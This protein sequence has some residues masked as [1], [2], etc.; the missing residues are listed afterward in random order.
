MDPGILVG[1]VIAVGLILPMIYWNSINDWPM[2]H[3]YQQFTGDFSGGGPLNFFITQIAII[4]I[5][6]APIF[7]IG[8]YFYLRSNEGNGLRA[9]GLTYIILYIFMT[10]LNLKT[11]Y[12]M[13]VY[14]MLYAG[15]ALL[16]EK[17]SNS[18][19]GVFRWFGSRPFIAS[20]VV[21]AL[22]LAPVVM[23]ILSPPT[24][25][26]KYGSSDYQMVNA[27]RYGWSKMVSNLS[28]AYDV[29]PVYVKD[30]ACIFTSN[31][32]E[33]S[34]INF[35]GPSLGL[36]K[37]ISGHN[38]Y[39]IWGPGSCSGKVLIT[40]GI[41]L[42]SYQQITQNATLLTTLECQYCISYEQNLPVYLWYNQSFS[43]VAA[44]PQL[45][46]YD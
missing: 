7:V 13:P 35:F 40:V 16:I 27:D 31:Y 46:H 39:Y 15:G 36:P 8:L 22:L 37:A 12:L 19:K 29:L 18:N 1:G 42:N 24:M 11:Y 9:L 17:S 41:P 34:A 6:N 33:A 32:G 25:I 38:N 28:K 20:L 43:L 26:S 21:V 14:P 23:P 10:I 44:W 45:R 2:L 4:S 30:Q 5:L 3:F